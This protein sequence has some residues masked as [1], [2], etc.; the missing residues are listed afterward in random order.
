[1]DEATRLA[2]LGVIDVVGIFTR[3]DTVETMEGIP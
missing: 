3:A 1:M 2:D